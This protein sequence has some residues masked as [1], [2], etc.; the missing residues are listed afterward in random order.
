MPLKYWHDSHI[1]VPCAVEQWCILRY[2]ALVAMSN[3][4]LFET[5]LRRHEIALALVA[6]NAHT[7]QEQ[8]SGSRAARK[9]KGSKTRK[10]KQAQSGQPV[11]YAL[12]AGEAFTKW[13]AR[14]VRDV[15]P[16]KD[17]ALSST[18][19]K[20]GMRGGIQ[21][22]WVELKAPTVVHPGRTEVLTSQRVAFMDGML[23]E[24][25]VAALSIQVSFS[26]PAFDQANTSAVT[27]LCKI[28][29][30]NAAQPG[31]WTL[32]SCS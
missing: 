25:F 21:E 5:W 30:P 32:S 2:A 10:A 16:L 20:Q 4:Q 1:F 26:C 15:P 14:I 6:H 9:D 17:I 28:K 24:D 29:A 3:K 12:K 27:T 13:L 22:E 7:A 11:K 31:H 18:A 19:A 23:Y 8:H